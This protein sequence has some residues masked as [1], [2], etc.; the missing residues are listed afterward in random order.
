MRPSTR[1]SG[2]AEMA[3]TTPEI[4]YKVPKRHHPVVQFAVTQPL[5]APGW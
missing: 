2:I 5:G 3:V 4:T 1:A